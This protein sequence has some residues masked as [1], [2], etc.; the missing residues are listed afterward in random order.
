MLY[1]FSFLSVFPLCL[2]IF[3]LP[4]ALSQTPGDVNSDGFTNHDDLLLVKDHLL[5]R[6]SLQGDSLISADANQD[7]KIDVADMLTIDI[8]TTTFSIPLIYVPSDTF[9]MGARDDGDDGTYRYSD[10]L[11][12]HEVTLSAYYIGKYEI[13][14]EQYCEVLNWAKGMGYLENSGGGS[15]TGGNVYKNG[16]ILLYVDSYCQIVYSDGSFTWKYRDGYS[17]ENHPVVVVSWYGSVA[18]CNW[19]SEKEGKTPAYNLSTWELVNKNGGGYRLPTEAEWERAAAWDGSKHWIYG[20]TS[21][22]GNN[23]N[24]YNH[25]DDLGGTGYVN[26]LG[27]SD[28]PYTSPVGWFNGVNISPNGSVQTINSPSP[29]GCYDMS[30]N[31]WE[32]CHDWY[33]STYYNGGAMIDPNGPASGSYLVLRGGGWDYSAQSCRSADRSDYDPTY[34]DYDIGFR[35]ALRSPAR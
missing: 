12:R 17:M 8:N 23:R 11:P 13:T 9:T 35:V 32:W 3:P 33:S 26:P 10:E 30:G 7:E 25:Y 2:L 14:N 1:S 22:N 4:N 18:F 20:Y 21:D 16:Y 34:A 28:Y 24:R 29:V 19:L 31:V 27:L 5:D 15:Y 6:V